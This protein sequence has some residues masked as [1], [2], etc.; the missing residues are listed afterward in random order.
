MSKQVHAGYVSF[1]LSGLTETG[2]ITQYMRDIGSDADAL[3]CGA[4]LI[5]LLGLESD[6]THAKRFHIGQMA[7]EAFR[8]L[9]RVAVLQ[10]PS[11]LRG[12]T[13]MVA[14]NRGLVAES[15]TRVDEA[16]AW[17]ARPD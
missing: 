2:L 8:P 13:A 1:A 5:D 6:L 4:V 15:F 17:L 14:S 7:A 9:R 3:A 16:V 12:F 11:E 10:Q